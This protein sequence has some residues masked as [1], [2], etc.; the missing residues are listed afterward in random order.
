[1]IIEEKELISNS[2]FGADFEVFIFDEENNEVVNAKPF[3]KGTKDKPFN[4]DERDKWFSTSLDNV[5]AEGNIP[6]VTNEDDFDKNI[7]YVLNY[8]Q[9]IL[10][11]N[12]KI[13]SAPAMEL[14]PKYLKTREAKLH[15]CEKDYSAW[16]MNTINHPDA[17]STNIRTGCCH[18]HIRYDGMDIKTGI[19]LIKAMDLFLGVPSILIEPDNER[20]NIYGAAGAFRYNPSKTLEYRV[21]SNY[22]LNSSELRKWVY[23]NTQAAINFVN[24]RYEFDDEVLNSKIVSCIN[25]ADKDLAIELISEFNIDMV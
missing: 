16:T 20:R 5:L 21:L 12:H 2:S 8:I 7:E 11:Q 4:F 10:P 15:G 13:L 17:K 23:R 22:F 1:M 19:K 3:I 9:S 25:N 18:V 14:K 6:P 24:S